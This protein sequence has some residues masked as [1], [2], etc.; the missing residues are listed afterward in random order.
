ME[1]A[2]HVSEAGPCEPSTG[3]IACD[4]QPAITTNENTPPITRSLLIVQDEETALLVNALMVMSS[5]SVT[6]DG[7]RDCQRA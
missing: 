3:E 5:S 6:R 2:G 7:Y 4:A 1:F